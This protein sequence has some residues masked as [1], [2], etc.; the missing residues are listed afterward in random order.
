MPGFFAA[1][2]NDKEKIKLVNYCE[3]NCLKGEMV[4]GELTIKR[5]ILNSFI[6]DKLFFENEEIAVATDGIILNSNKLLEKYEKNTLTE[7]VELLAITNKNFFSE[8]EGTFSG[9]VYYKC[10]NKIVAFTGPL[11]DHAIFYYYN[12][13]KNLFA[14]GSQ[15][16][17]IVDYL[18]FMNIP[19]TEDVHGISCFLDYGYF[20]DDSTCINEIKRLYPGDFIVVDLENKKAIIDSYYKIDVPEKTYTIDEAIEN[21]DIA[22]CNAISRL[23]NKNREYGYKNLLDLSGGMDS[24]AI[25]YTAKRLGYEDTF[26]ITYSQSNSNEEKI[27]K[28]IAT[29]LGF[30]WYYKILDN[31][32]CVTQIEDLMFMNSGTAYYIGI[33]GG[34]DFLEILNNHKVG[35]EFTGLLGDVKENTM[36]LEDGENPPSLL[37]PRYRTSKLRQLNKNTYSN[38]INEFKTHEIFWFYTRGMLAGMSTFLTRQ[39]FVEPATP[40]GDKEFIET[41]FSIPW[42]QRTENNILLLWMEKKYP[43]AIRIPYAATGISVKNDFAWYNVFK[44]RTKYYSK[45]ILCKINKKPVV[46]DMNPVDYWLSNKEELVVFINDYYENNFNNIKA[47]IEIKKRIEDLFVNA[48]CFN[49]KMIA[50]SAIAYYKLYLR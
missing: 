34:K 31:G 43:E 30:D 35:I 40:F 50:L 38:R 27:A 3:S 25:C 48:S 9:C 29:N 12:D 24:R 23:A 33:T 15:L 8:F 45:K 41:F 14:I 13:K 20:I 17:Y 21:I 1:N 44:R 7:L 2:C 22:F 37:N 36:T 11:G 39:N 46:N 26:M 42:K 16:N 49:D 32:K 4:C 47:S 19:T 10:E 18:K 6:N 28:K 5:N